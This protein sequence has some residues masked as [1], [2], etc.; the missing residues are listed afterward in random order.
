[1]I[2][3]KCCDFVLG[4]GMN[5]FQLLKRVL[6]GINLDGIF[7]EKG[8]EETALRV[9]SRCVTT[10]AKFDAEMLRMKRRVSVSKK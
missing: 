8:K 9:A 1:M 10:Q 6:F 3:L 4:G 7:S 2:V 5:F